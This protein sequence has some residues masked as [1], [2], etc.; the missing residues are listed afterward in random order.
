MRGLR[1]HKLHLLLF[2]VVETIDTG[3]TRAYSVMETNGKGWVTTAEDSKSKL[4]KSRPKVECSF[5]GA[6]GVGSGA[7]G[8]SDKGGIGSGLGSEEEVDWIGC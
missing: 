5:R 6:E 2:K 7:E 8:C 3:P 4:R 1:N